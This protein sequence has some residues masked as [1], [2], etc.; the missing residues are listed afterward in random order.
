VHLAQRGAHYRGF[1]KQFPHLV[2][3]EPLHRVNDLHTLTAQ[4]HMTGGTVAGGGLLL[5]VHTAVAMHNTHARYL[6]NGQTVG[7]RRLHMYGLSASQPS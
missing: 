1:L 6:D 2:L 7:N 5:C 4:V 3:G